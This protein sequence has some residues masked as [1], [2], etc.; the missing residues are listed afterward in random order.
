[1]DKDPAHPRLVLRWGRILTAIALVGLA[2]YLSLATALWGY[3]SIYRKI[4]GVNWVDVA[5]LPRFPRVQAAI[6]ASYY[7]DARTLWD[8]KQF[9]PAI[10]TA[11]AA[12]G[13]SPGNL[14]ARLF[15][16]GCWQ[17]AGR[18]NEAI[19][20]LTDGIAFSAED[21]RLQGM[22]VG[23]CLETSH[24]K[25]LLKI[26]REDF[27]TH[28]VHLLDGKN[29]VYQMAEVR[30]LLET[31][32]AAEAD[33]VA[34]S[35]PGLKDAP[36]AAPLFAGIDWELG[37]HDAAV[38]RIR[39]ALERQPG[40][41]GL[42]DADV[43]MALRA[44]HTDDAR[45]AA[46]RFL[47]A[48]PNLLSAQLKFLDAHGSRQGADSRLWTAE[49]ARF[50]SQYRHQPDALA[51]LSSL[52]ASQGWPDLAFLLYQNSLQE[53]LTGFPFAIYYAGS[54]VKSGKL[55]EADAVWRDLSLRNQPQIASA[56]Y[57]AAM[58]D[59]GTGRVSEAMQAIDQLRRE[60]ADDPHRRRVIEGVFRSFGYTQ[61]ADQFA[62]GH[63]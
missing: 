24:F 3:Y 19:R 22:V 61:L 39:T 63:S 16:A 10:F 58:V 7:A 1:V 20:T 12:V 31:S 27:P 15:L 33:R 59:W 46:N 44:G 4:P 54:L 43:D 29:R 2:G 38:A 34:A 40:D 51:Q 14:E 11:R 41:P 17:Q 8:K 47:T 49:C 57:I 53:N 60:N 21:T 23:L 62:K 28:G 9:V 26:L 5:I 25:D 18:P 37:R 55:A 42:L 30:A 48:F 36:S 56:A 13:K 50:L 32:G 45:A 6:G 35:Y 52:A